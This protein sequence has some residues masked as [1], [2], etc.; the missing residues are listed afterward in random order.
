[1]WSYLS[2]TLMK[3]T[4]YSVVNIENVYRFN[5]VTMETLNDEQKK[6]FIENMK[7]QMGMSFFD[8][9]KMHLFRKI[10]NS[11]LLKFMQ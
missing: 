8:D 2:S 10:P 11:E 3:S 4:N 5:V 9:F 1:M 6:K 7:L